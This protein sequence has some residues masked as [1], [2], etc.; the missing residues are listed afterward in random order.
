MASGMETMNERYRYKAME[1]KQKNIKSELAEFTALK[2]VNTLKKRYEGLLSQLSTYG[3]VYIWGTGRLGKF[4]FDQCTGN[5][6]HVAGYIDND[7]E[8]WNQS[9]QI[10]S[11]H[12]LK[13][14]DIVIIASFFYPEIMEQIRAL[15]LK[16]YIY[17]EEFAYLIE[18]METYYTAFVDIFEELECNKDKYAQVY[19]CLEDELSKEIYANILL[20]KATLDTE[21]TKEALRLSN[22]QGKEDLDKVVARE[23]DN[24]YS[25]FDVGGFDGSST[26]D[27]IRFTKGY[28]KIY[29]FEPDKIILEG[30]KDR[31]KDYSD[32]IYMCAAVGERSGHKNYNPI[33]D[34]AGFVSENETDISEPVE[35]VALDDLVKSHK[36]YIKM[37]IEG[38]ELEALKGA[39]KVIQSLKPMLSISAYHKTKDLHQIIPLILS[40]NPEYQVYLRHYRNNY[41]DTRVYFINKNNI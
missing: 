19:D 23:L 38:Y 29:F 37:D 27:Y 25:F 1:R 14:D 31:L 5:N 4:C 12:V 7:E 36:S 2:A 20:F 8:K 34:G 13:R 30:A 16:Y 39:K 3:S 21:Y 17:Y 40:W 33:G 24:E 10:F 26:M 28:Y 41:S 22:Q 9:E 6:I 18:G 35:I 32:I 15:G 11:F